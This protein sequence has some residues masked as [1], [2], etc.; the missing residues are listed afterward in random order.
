MLL[1]QLMTIFDP[2]TNK[3]FNSGSV[4]QETQSD[5]GETR[6]RLE[7]N[8]GQTVVKQ[9]QTVILPRNVNPG[10]PMG[11]NPF[12]YNKINESQEQSTVS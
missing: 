11:S 7:W 6:V 5:W 4:S 9:Q 10:L 8:N 2:F 1:K 3:S 12:N